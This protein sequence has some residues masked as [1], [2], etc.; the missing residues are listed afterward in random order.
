MIR[1]VICDLVVIK[2]N[3]ISWHMI[4]LYSS[5]RTVSGSFGSFS[6]ITGGTHLQTIAVVNAQ[7]CGCM[8]CGSVD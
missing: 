4:L 1:K 6:A 2:D 8:A 5:V 7:A 3:E